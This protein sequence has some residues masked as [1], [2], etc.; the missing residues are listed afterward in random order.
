MNH[1]API[2]RYPAGGIGAA[3]HQASPHAQEAYAKSCAQQT[4]QGACPEVRGMPLL[5]RAVNAAIETAAQQH[6]RLVNAV[7][8]VCGP[9]PTIAADRDPAPPSNGVVE[10]ITERFRVL[11][12]LF[13][14]INYEIGRLERVVG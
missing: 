5:L 7:D 10:E 6:G 1:G 9:E 13:D 11:G 12:Y 4:T 14:R 3:A 2:G 8:Y